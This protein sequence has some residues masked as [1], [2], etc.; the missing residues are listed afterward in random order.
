MILSSCI[1]LH[2]KPFV[3]SILYS[4]HSSVAPWLYIH[5]FVVLYQSVFNCHALLYMCSSLISQ[6][7]TVSTNTKPG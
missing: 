7:C 6:H 5:S 4:R 3:V 2:P 1:Q